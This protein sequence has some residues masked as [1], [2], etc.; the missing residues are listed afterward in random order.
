MTRNIIIFINDLWRRDEPDILGPRAKDGE[1]A[2]LVCTQERVLIH[3]TAHCLLERIVKQGLDNGASL[4]LA[5]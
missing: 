2:E 5:Y 3:F 4:L 1:I